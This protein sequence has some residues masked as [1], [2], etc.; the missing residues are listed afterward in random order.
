L[1]I[2]IIS[3]LLLILLELLIKNF[4]NRFKEIKW[5]I[6]NKNTIKLFNKNKFNNF[7]K[8]NYNYELGWDK[9]KN[10][11]N[12]DLID[13]KKISY[14]I[15]QNGYRKSS[16]SKKINTITTFG[17]SYTF[18]R[19]VKNSQTWQ[20][21]I[22]KNK[23]EFVSNYGVGNYGLDQ[24][25]L[26]FK[27]T[28]INKNS[29]I[30]IFSFVP[31]TI[32]RIQ[33]AWKNYL[34]FGNIHGFKP[35]CILKNN[36]LIIK[37]NPLKSFH[38][39][40]NLQNIIN[41][42]KRIDRFYKEKYLKYYIK[43]PYVI[44]F[45]KNF[46]FNIKFFYLILKNGKIKNFKILNRKI[47]PVIMENNIKLSHSLYKE[48]YSQKILEK[49]IY[50]IN[51]NINN[52]NKRCYFLIIPQ[53]N[54]LKSSSRLNYQKFFDSLKIKYKILDLTKDFLK[55]KDYQKFYINDKYGGHLN[56]KG[57]KFISRIIIKHLI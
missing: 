50:K 27:K 52:Q 47:F 10:R 33:S 17:D 25:Y 49:L 54:D 40:N 23:N 41:Y 26:K 2:F 31:E 53:L 22:S 13:G 51:S 46:K 1:S 24:S 3:L 19:Q 14:S 6:T 5:L 36:R 44:S 39:F 42:T 34:E 11:K 16:Y 55:I 35:F 57:N 37:K 15:D 48:K 56:K 38:K 45:F 32:C 7:K 21:L 12:F 9:K 4:I 18:C 43:F 28:K 29:K 20:E 8:K 30:I